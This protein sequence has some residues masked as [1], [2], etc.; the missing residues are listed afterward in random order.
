LPLGACSSPLRTGIYSHGHE[1][2]RHVQQRPALVLIQALHVLDPI[3]STRRNTG[4][5]R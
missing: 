2:A 5:F 1:P 4:Y 3:A